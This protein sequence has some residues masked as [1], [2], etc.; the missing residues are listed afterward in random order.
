[1]SASSEILKV[2]PLL[3]FMGGNFR[4]KM[5]SFEKFEIKHTAETNR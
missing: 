2:P 4:G 5:L 3:A 1:M